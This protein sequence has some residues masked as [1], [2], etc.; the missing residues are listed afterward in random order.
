[1]T[2]DCVLLCSCGTHDKIALEK[3]TKED[4]NSTVLYAIKRKP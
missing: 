4:H 2:L 1:M 3:S